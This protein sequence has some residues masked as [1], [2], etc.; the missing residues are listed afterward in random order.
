[1]PKRILVTG[2]A[3]GL[4]RYLLDR[5]GT[6]SI[7]RNDHPE[8]HIKDS[9]YDAIIHCAIDKQEKD[10]ASKATTRNITLLKRVVRIPHHTFIQISSTDVYQKSVGIKSEES[11]TIERYDKTPY[12]A[13]KLSCESFVTAWP[14]NH[15]I[16]RATAMLGK[17]ARPN[18]LMHMLLN[19][20]HELSLHPKSTFNYILHRQ[21][22]DFIISALKAN[23]T[24]VFNLASS[25]NLTLADA[26]KQVKAE[27][28][29]G[30]FQYFTPNIKNDKAKI[31][32]PD[33]EHDSAWA[34]NE[35]M[36]EYP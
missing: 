7:T 33:L 23:H 32:L 21:I 6:T 14:S 24:G 17:S 31:V 5:Y 1:M 36:K 4:G 3:S 20:K 11:E 2:T 28:S 35:F 9:P 15:L 12:E 30:N 26:A 34:I 8:N 25:G 22:G 29:F 27:P 18:S 16:I 10:N 13:I 19:P